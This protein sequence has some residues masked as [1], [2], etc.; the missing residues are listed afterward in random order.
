VTVIVKDGL[1]SGEPTIEMPPGIIR[2]QEIF[3]EKAV[4]IASS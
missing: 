4:H 1:R 2:Q 3:S